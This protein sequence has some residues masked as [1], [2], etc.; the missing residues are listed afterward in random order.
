VSASSGSGAKPLTFLVAAALLCAH[1]Q[2]ATLRAAPHDGFTR[3]VFDFAQPTSATVHRQ[4][5]TVAIAFADHA[6]ITPPPGFDAANLP[7]LRAASFTPGRVTL[8]LPAGVRVR[9]FAIGARRVI[10]LY[11]PSAPPS[12]SSSPTA[13]AAQSVP[14]APPSPAAITFPALTIDPPPPSAP[15]VA[16]ILDP[17]AERLPRAPAQAEPDDPSAP[18]VLALPAGTGAAAFR[19]GDVG[20]VVFDVNRAIDP[21]S[22]HRQAGFAQAT[23]ETLPDAVI[24]RVPLPPATSLA[25][26]HQ[27]VEWAIALTTTPPP[28]DV[29]LQPVATEGR[30]LLPTPPG[31]VVAIPD[32]LTADN[33]L[34]GTVPAP[35]SHVGAARHFAQF[36]LLPTMLGVAIDPLADSVALHAQQ[37]DFVVEASDPTGSLSLSPQPAAAAS[38]TTGT[39]S[40]TLPD[41]TA[42]ALWRRLEV[43]TADAAARPLGARLPDRRAV[44]Q[45]LLALGMGAE[46]QG[47]LQV[48][49]TDDPRALSDPRTQTIA[50]AAALLAGRLGQTAA[51]AA[52][53]HPT[54]ELKLWRAL[55]AGARLADSATPDPAT[56]QALAA[57]SDLLLTYPP[58]LRHRLLPLA[59][60]ILLRGGAIAAVGHLLAAAPD[61][62][63][64]DL[65]RAAAL[66]AQG[67]TDA[68]LAAYDRLAQ[69]NDRSAR[70]RAAVAALDLRLATKR[71]TPAEAA[72]AGNRMLYAWRGDARERDLRLRIAR[73]QGLA[74]DPR[75]QLETL[76]DALHLFPDPA[77]GIQTVLTTAFTTMMQAQSRPGASL[78]APLDFVTLMQENADLLPDGPAG[79]A[80]VAQLADQLM[81][82]DLPGQAAPLLGRLLATTQAPAPRAAIGARLAAIDLDRNDAQ[83][84]STALSASAADPAALTSPLLNRRAL[85]QSRIDAALG[86]RP[87]ALSSLASIDT[88]PALLQQASLHE[89][90]HDWRAAASDLARYAAQ[91]I[92]PDGKLDPTQSGVVLRWA[93]ALGQ[94]TD[95]AGL[96]KLRAVYATRLPDKDDATLF[97]V[98]TEP[99]VRDPADLPRAAAETLAARALPQA[100]QAIHHVE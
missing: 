88:P 95:E 80:L 61:D 30:L 32:P 43:Q 10:D 83:S 49:A 79:E 51:L 11:A 54:D 44:A 82:L 48:A 85:L 28:P 40:F 55:R 56:T 16:R 84:A 62:H 1:A 93:S 3:L 90:G 71:L 17:A 65:A 31:H 70:A 69:E 47:V 52:T 87:V 37:K 72:A 6:P 15:P 63:G 57:G 41:E 97:G 86:N 4:A 60:D 92:P 7:N 74:G 18:A 75:Q 24:L 26:T 53:E 94:A 36:D 68:A 2:A 45:T 13:F 73:W 29:L 98:L 33:L 8:T 89:D 59:A 5:N 42:S 22:L 21:A 12:R 77:D 99:P 91:N 39:R 20:I 66:Q 23:V 81:A 35:V 64:L 46:A 100:L 67:K 78:L 19:R 34:V 58:T 9:S 76:R 38:T 14:L 25:V 96:A 27:G 50:A